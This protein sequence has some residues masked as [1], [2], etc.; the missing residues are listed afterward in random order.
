MPSFEVI[1][2]VDGGLI[3]IEE[4]ENKGKASS[5]CETALTFNV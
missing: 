4:W 3:S 2:V 5:L 1:T